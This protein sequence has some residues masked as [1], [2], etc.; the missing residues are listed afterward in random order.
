MVTRTRNGIFKPEAFT[1]KPDYTITEPPTFIQ[2]C[3]IYL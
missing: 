1:T 2:E 3:E